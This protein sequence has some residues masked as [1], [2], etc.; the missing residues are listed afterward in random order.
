[1]S[2]LTTI[3]SALAAVF[4]AA[5]A[6]RS[7]KL[8][9]SIQNEMKSD[10]V[11]IPGAIAHPG[12]KE[13]SHADAVIQVPIFN[14]SKRK[15]F[16]DALTVF[17]RNGNPIEVTWSSKIDDCG[18]MSDSSRLIGIIDSAT[19]YI[20]RN[21]GEALTYARILFK[22]SFSEIRCVTVFDEYAD[23]TKV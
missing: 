4:S 3:L 8:A 20:R 19:V 12:L 13:R 22:H 18:N 14:K 2:T 23:F 6:F 7:F 10:E 15:A 16:I 17:D 5:T 9:Q 21:D 11:L 1:M